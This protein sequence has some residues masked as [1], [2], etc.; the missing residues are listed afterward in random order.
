VNWFTLEPHRFTPR[1]SGVAV[2]VNG[3]VSPANSFAATDF[4]FDASKE[5]GRSFRLKFQQ[6]ARRHSWR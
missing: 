5:A 1:R 3:F 4:R 6:P 2:A